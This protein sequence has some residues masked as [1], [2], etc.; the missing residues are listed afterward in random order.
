MRDYFMHGVCD[1][2]APVAAKS[3]RT[4]GALPTG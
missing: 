4:V 1:P 2:A 3:N